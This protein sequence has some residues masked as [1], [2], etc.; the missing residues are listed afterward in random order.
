MNKAIG[1]VSSADPADVNRLLKIHKQRMLQLE[2][3]SIII[4][5]GRERNE[6][7][8]WLMVFPPFYHC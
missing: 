2:G 5:T 3:Q 1:S 4:C 7:I 8:K 6:F